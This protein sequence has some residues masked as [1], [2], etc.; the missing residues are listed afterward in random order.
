MDRTCSRSEHG[1]RVRLQKLLRTV[2]PRSPDGDAGVAIKFHPVQDGSR[3]IFNR[4]EFLKADQ[5]VACS[6]ASGLL[7]EEE[8][9]EVVR[10]GVSG[11]R[12]ERTSSQTKLGARRAP[13]MHSVAHGTSTQFNNF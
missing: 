11:W 10:E 7:T 1:L 5:I 9:P 4:H 12:P 6:L 8:V 3:R 13:R 2:Q